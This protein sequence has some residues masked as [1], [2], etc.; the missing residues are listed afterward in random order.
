M[1]SDNDFYKYN[2]YNMNIHE[3]TQV[4]ILFYR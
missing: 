3:Y 1:F 4:L 2:I